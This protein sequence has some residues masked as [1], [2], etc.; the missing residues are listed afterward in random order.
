MPDRPIH[1]IVKHTKLIR[2]TMNKMHSQLV[3]EKHCDNSLCDEMTG[4][5][6]R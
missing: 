2:L 6:L 5:L 3:T 4:I 1:Q